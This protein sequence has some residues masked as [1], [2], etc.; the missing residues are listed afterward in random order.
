MYDKDWGKL[1]LTL[2]Q[3]LSNVCALSFKAEAA[4]RAEFKKKDK[5][6]F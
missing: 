6:K 5:Y 4:M 1:A 3:Y 2:V